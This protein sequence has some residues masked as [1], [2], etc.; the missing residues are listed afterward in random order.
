MS[1]DR[2]PADVI[3]IVEFLGEWS[4]GYGYL[5]WNEIAR[6]K[7][8]LKNM[9]RRWVGVD[10]AAFRAKC[11]EVGLTSKEADELTDYLKKAQ[12]GRRLIPE[13]GYRD[14]YFRPEPD[15]DDPVRL[16][17]REDQPGPITSREW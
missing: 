12:A 3:D 15:M 11:I 9:K 4:A 7:G 5:K 1:D 13:R 16:R 6:F 8:D 17:A 2:L 14:D 10:R